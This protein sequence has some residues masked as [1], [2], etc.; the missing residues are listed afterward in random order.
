MI[1]LKINQLHTYFLLEVITRPTK[2]K[3][4][5]IRQDTIE[6]KVRMSIK[7]VVTRLKSLCC[8]KILWYSTNLITKCR[9][10]KLRPQQF[11]HFSP[12]ILLLYSSK[13]MILTLTLTVCTHWLSRRLFFLFTSFSGL[14]FSFFFFYSPVIHHC[15]CSRIYH[16]FALFQHQHHHHVYV[17]NI[18]LL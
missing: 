2:K 8:L 6:R 9:N 4:T 18:S 5:N 7:F 14:L 17:S 1:G 3:F 16:L 10:N 13:E 15:H 11:I 12:F